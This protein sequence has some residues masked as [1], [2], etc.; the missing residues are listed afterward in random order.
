MTATSTKHNEPLE[1]VI[2][3]IP[4]FPKQDGRPTLAGLEGPAKMIALQQQRAVRLLD[5]LET[6]QAT[7]AKIA[8]L[9]HW[10]R[11]FE[12]LNA[13]RAIL[14]ASTGIA[15]GMLARICMEQALQIQVILDPVL[16]TLGKK[17][18]GS[19]PIHI[20]SNAKERYWHE[21]IERLNAYAA[22][23]LHS[24]SEYYK[25]LS[26]K[27][28]LDEIWEEDSRRSIL[29]D[30]SAKRMHEMLYGPIEVLS[31][32]E[33]ALDR[34]KHEKAIR[35]DFR[36][37]T[38][39]LSSKSI[40]P[41]RSRI[42]D[43]IKASKS[44]TPTFFE[45]FSETEQTIRKRLSAQGLGFA[46]QSYQRGSLQIHGSTVDRVLG[47]AENTLIPRLADAFDDTTKD[48]ADVASWCSHILVG[49]HL[50]KA[51]VFGLPHA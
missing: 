46:Y 45:L 22:W 21:T 49:L 24:D 17:S 13:T 44:R 4:S 51:R 41:W 31:D 11:A 6:T 1:S 2:L 12:L 36:R 50:L 7:F 48:S 16:S 29:R 47:F 5:D 42:A 10:T 35:E 25:F 20:S 8:W 26:E 9:T 32:A 43:C 33:V 3:W 34:K 14:D 40:L 18:K 27:R 23:C 37:V 39:W 30:P 28:T 15:S 38:S 19:N